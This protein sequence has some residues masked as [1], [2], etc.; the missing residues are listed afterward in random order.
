MSHRLLLSLPSSVAALLVPL[1]LSLVAGCKVKSPP[2]APGTSGKTE[3][4]AKTLSEEGAATSGGSSARRGYRVAEVTDGGVLQA[5]VTFTGT[6]PEPVPVVVNIN[7]EHCGGKVRDESL[8]VDSESRGLANVVLR[9]EG[10]PH[11]KAPAKELLVENRTCAFDP[12]VSVAVAKPRA[13]AKFKG[14]KVKPI[15]R[16]PFLHTTAAT[17]AGLQIFNAPMPSAG[18]SYPGKVPKQTGPL[19]LRCDVHKWMQAWVYVHDTPYL[20]VSDAQGKVEIDQIPPGTYEY[21]AWHEKLGEQRGK[22]TL[23]AKETVE[24]KVA[25]GDALSR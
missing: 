16:D 3:G 25:F 8:L 17:I 9:L 20:A 2:A 12:H 21:V 11:G 23:G 22:V 6:I 14:T 4:E 24:L 13:G 19:Q 10:V 7:V 1:F 15:N 5:T 18:D